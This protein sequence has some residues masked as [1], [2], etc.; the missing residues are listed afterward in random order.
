MDGIKPPQPPRQIADIDLT[1]NNGSAAKRNSGRPISAENT[2]H[3]SPAAIMRS[4]GFEPSKHMTPLQFMIA[5]Y[6]DDV[7][8]IY[9]NPIRLAKTQRLGGIAIGYRLEAAKVA[10][11]YMHMEMPK[12]T[13]NEETSVFGDK[14]AEAQAS[15]DDR[16]R[17]KTMIIETIERISPDV[18]LDSA[19]YP[20]MYGFNPPTRVANEE[21][22]IEG[23]ILNPEGNKDYNPD[24]E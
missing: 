15:G 19:N 11:R 23:E 14:L 8:A 2:A 10:A 16:L 13:F 21:G 1:G 4:M 12:V 7:E 5:L 18:P 24:A 17:K 6:N 3:R 22:I 9:K 20:E